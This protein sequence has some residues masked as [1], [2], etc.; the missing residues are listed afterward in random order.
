M[1][2]LRKLGR[3]RWWLVPLLRPAAG[4]DLGGRSLA[5]LPVRGTDLGTAGSR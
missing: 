2:G 4:T 5:D 3:C 1:G